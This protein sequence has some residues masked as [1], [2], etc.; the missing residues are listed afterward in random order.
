V[1]A[2]GTRT[3]LPLDAL[4]DPTLDI[5]VANAKEIANISE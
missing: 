1:V 4:I 2:L 3:V 5:F